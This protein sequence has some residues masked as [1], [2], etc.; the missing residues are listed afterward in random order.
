MPYCGVKACKLKKLIAASN[1]A[2]LTI[3]ALWERKVMET[4]NH[5]VKSIS[6]K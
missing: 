5:L 6:M 4:E 2:G 1:A 3:K